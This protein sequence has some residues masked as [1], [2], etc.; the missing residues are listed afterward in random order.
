MNEFNFSQ[1]HII[2]TQTL[3][4][5]PIKKSCPIYC[6]FKARLSVPRHRNVLKTRPSQPFGRKEDALQYVAT[7]EATFQLPVPVVVN[8]RWILVSG[9]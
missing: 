1:W 4:R 6:F 8:N 7:A 9:P 2:P 5:Y 3:F